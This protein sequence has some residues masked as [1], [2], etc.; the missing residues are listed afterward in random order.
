VNINRKERNFIRPFVLYR[1]SAKEWVNGKYY[2]DGDKS[3]PVRVGVLC[4]SL[5]EKGIL[6]EVSTPLGL[7]RITDLGRSFECACHRGF[8]YNDNDEATEK[9]DICEGTGLK[10]TSRIEK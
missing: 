10:L 6:H 7:I 8:K 5:I 3:M 9:C 2:L 4:K 1:W